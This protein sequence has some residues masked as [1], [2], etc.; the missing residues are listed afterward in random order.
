MGSPEGFGTKCCLLASFPELSLVRLLSSHLDAGLLG[1][2]EC[3]VQN[4]AA[5]AAEQAVVQKA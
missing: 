4:P 3:F 5:A 1:Y 2:W